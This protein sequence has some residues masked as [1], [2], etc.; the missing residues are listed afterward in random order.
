MDQLTSTGP[1]KL[2][3]ADLK[4]VTLP[5]EIILQI[6]DELWSAPQIIP[7]EIFGPENVIRPKMDDK[8][9]ISSQTK[10]VLR[11]PPLFAGAGSACRFFRHSYCQ[12]RPETWGAHLTSG[13]SYNIDMHRD[14]FHVRIH[15][16]VHPNEWDRYGKSHQDPLYGLLDGIERLATSPNYIYPRVNSEGGNYLR[17]MHPECRELMILVPVRRSDYSR[18]PGLRRS[19]ELQPMTNDHYIRAPLVEQCRSWETFKKWVRRW[20]EIPHLTFSGRVRS[21]SLGERELWEKTWRLSPVP[22]LKGYLIDEEILN[23]P[24]AY[25]LWV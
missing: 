7:I 8:G 22:E 15:R 21:I 2:L 23:D 3:F 19:S 25:L 1:P 9:S 17:H 14:I 16:V 13:V 6:L 5:M 10:V 4:R 24:N 12:T 18:L 11:P 20:M